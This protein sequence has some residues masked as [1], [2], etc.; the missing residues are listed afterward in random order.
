MK[1]KIKGYFISHPHFDHS[2]GLVINSPE[3]SKKN[4]YAAEFVIEAPNEGEKPILGKYTYKKLNTDEW[5]SVENT[6]LQLKMYYLSHT[7][8]NLSSAA[9][10]KNTENQYFVYLGDTGADRIEGTEQLADLWK[11]IAPIIKEKRLKGIAIE[12]SYSNE[13]PENQLYGHLTPR[14]LT[15]E[16]ENLEKLV[17]EEGLKGL[18]L[19]ITH[20]KPK[21]NIHQK[22]KT[23]LNVLYKKGIKIIF[24]EQGKVINL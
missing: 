6:D 20:I 7:G 13:Q 17:G 2:S 3:D 5:M 9:L 1:K 15:E 18:N 16:M 23:E 24:A 22:V 11:A 19:I 4:I 8:K 14:L 10:V 21:K 12:C